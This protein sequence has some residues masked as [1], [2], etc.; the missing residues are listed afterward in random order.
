LNFTAQRS[1]KQKGN[2]KPKQQTDGAAYR[3][4]EKLTYEIRRCV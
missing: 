1:C 2:G 3:I 4:E